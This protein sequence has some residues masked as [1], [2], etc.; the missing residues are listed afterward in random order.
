MLMRRVLCGLPA[1]QT[2]VSHTLPPSAVQVKYTGR[3][4]TISTT[5]WAGYAVG[6]S[7]TPAGH[8]HPTCCWSTSRLTPTPK[9]SSGFSAQERASGEPW[10]SRG[11]RDRCA[12]GWEDAEEE[13][14]EE[15]AVGGGGAAFSAW[16]GAAASGSSGSDAASEPSTSLA[17]EVVLSPP[18][19]TPERLAPP[20][21]NLRVILMRAPEDGDDEE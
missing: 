4:V 13:E 7:E 12:R 14:E 10:P 11:S 17:L 15:A 21:R 5:A 16:W 3:L 8:P 18:A 1:L 9:S 6:V 2:L 20:M 19:P